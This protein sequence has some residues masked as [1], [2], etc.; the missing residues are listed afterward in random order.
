MNIREIITEYKRL[1]VP[2]WDGQ[3]FVVYQNPNINELHTLLGKFDLRGLLWD[4][5]F[6]VW[7]AFMTTHY[8]IFVNLGGEDD[9]YGTM[10]DRETVS[11]YM[12][13]QEE[14]GR[15]DSDWDLSP[16]ESGNDIIYIGFNDSGGMSHPMVQRALG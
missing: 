14:E 8:E 2:F 9:E 4:N 10:F 13:S 6:Y 5:K 16:Y 1:N 7:E 15:Y 3:D 12:S 11:F